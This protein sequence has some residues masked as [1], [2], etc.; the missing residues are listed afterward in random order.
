MSA[1][2]KTDTGL[3]E[4]DVADKISDPSVHQYLHQAE[5]PGQHRPGVPDRQQP[6]GRSAH[7]VRAARLRGRQQDQVDRRRTAVDPRRGAQPPRAC[8]PSS[9]TSTVCE[10]VGDAAGGNAAL[11]GKRAD[12]VIRR[13]TALGV[14]NPMQKVAGT[15]NVDAVIVRAAPPDPTIV[16][17]YVRQWSRISAAHEFG[18]MLG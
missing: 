15:S 8:R 3:K 10:V 11:A 13:L 18:H 6:V 12:N 17:T 16:N 2:G 7:P 4:F 14:K 9:P 1:W 5:T